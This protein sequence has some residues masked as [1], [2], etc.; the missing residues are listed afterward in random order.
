MILSLFRRSIAVTAVGGHIM[1]QPLKR[2]SPFSFLVAALLACGG[3]ST[4]PAQPP[5]GDYTAFQFVT[6]GGSGSTNQLLIGSTLQISL[7][8]NGTT[9]GHLHLAASGGNPPLDAD[10]AGTW[11]I[12]G[13]LGRR[14]VRARHGVHASANS[15]R[16][17][18]SGWRPGFLGNAGA[19]H[20]EARAI[21]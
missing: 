4:G 13:N 1:R 8:A 6:T 9:S 20:A 19:A 21:A 16:S 17:V 7:A 3:D 15:E 14:H 11:T 10:M 12:T 2:V 18:G 5:V